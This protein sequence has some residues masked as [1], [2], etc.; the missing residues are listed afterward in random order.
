M[1]PPAYGNCVVEEGEDHGPVLGAV[2]VTEDSGGNRGEAGL[3][4]PHQGPHRSERVILLSE[5]WAHLD[6]CDTSI[7]DALTHNTQY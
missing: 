1:L 6:I 3:P 2:E 7:M 4:K 5:D